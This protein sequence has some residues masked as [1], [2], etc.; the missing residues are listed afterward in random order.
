MK[1]WQKILLISLPIVLITVFLILFSILLF[2]F[3]NIDRITTDKNQYINLSLSGEILEKH[4]RDV[5]SQMMFQERPTLL[6]LLHN[7]Q[8]AQNDNSIKGIILRPQ[9]LQL[10]WGKLAELRNA[11]IKFKESGKVLVSF[12]ENATTRDYFL[13]TASEKIYMPP[14]GQLFL[15][16]LMS[17]MMFLKNTFDK[18]GVKADFEHIGRYK[19]AADTYTRNSMSGPHRKMINELLDDVFEQL[20]NAVGQARNITVSELR[21]IVDKGPFSGEIAV[22]Y[23]LVDSLMYLKQLDNLLGD[24]DEANSISTVAYQRYAR[25]QNFGYQFSFAPKVALIFA[26]GTIVSGKSGY[27]PYY[28]DVLG[29]ETLSRYIRKAAED[30]SIKAIVLRIDS[31]GGSGLAADA[32]WHEVELA[33]AQKPLIASMSDV[34]ASG[35][36]YIAMAADTIVAQPGTITG[37]IGVLTGKFNLKEL[38]NKLG[39][40]KEIINRGK[41]VD[42][43]SDYRGFTSEERRLIRKQ[44]RDFYDNF[45]AKAAKGR[46]RTFHQI[47]KVARGRVWSGRQALKIGLI[48]TL[49]GL[50]TA[51]KIA[52]KMAGLGEDEQIQIVVYPKGKI[53]LENLLKK[54]IQNMVFQYQDFQPLFTQH[55]LRIPVLF[56]DKQILALMPYSIEIK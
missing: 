53:W 18:I 16:G 48:D 27:N 6:G 38:Y 49:G 13:A 24:D 14:H 19:S 20:L 42:M 34:A 35:G 21:Q 11:L 31:P 46:G 47:D 7:I 9:N 10:G 15:V 28:G 29:S 43:Y 23:N 3:R 17:E 44:L 33:R 1:T 30:N 4:S 26:Q 12:I 36:Y 56:K 22:K 2:R 55:L 51:F 45:V 52:K 32:I 50:D 37:S 41:H 40:R 39:I 5:F 54:N 8:K 25:E